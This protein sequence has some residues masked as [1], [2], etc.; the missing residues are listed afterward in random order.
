[1]PLSNDEIM[2]HTNYSVTYETETT[3]TT[4]FAT[5]NQCSN[6]NCS[7]DIPLFLLSDQSYTL[8]VHGTTETNALVFPTEIG[9]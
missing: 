5:D 1:M 9:K 2:I 7:M 3:S 4:L 6:G 8:S